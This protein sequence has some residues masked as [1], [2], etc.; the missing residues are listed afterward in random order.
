GKIEVPIYRTLYLNQLLN[1]IKGTKITKN[2]EYKELVSN[3]N[4]ESLEEEMNISENLESTLRYYQKTGFKWLKI[5][6]RYKFGG[7]LADDMGLGKTIQM[8]SIIVDYVSNYNKN[9]EKRKKKKE[10]RAS[11]V[12]SPSSLTLNWQNEA[13]KFTSELETLVIKG[14]AQERRKQL[15]QVGK[16]DLVITSYEL[17]KRDIEIYKEQG[18]KFRF[19]IA[20]EAQ[21]LKNSTT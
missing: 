8:L 6:D 21:Y 13:R 3:L 15:E 10:K 16:Y 4:K 17:L 1:E 20:D 14:D 7:I 9:A 12:I 19:V 11:L 5:L 2:V 18:Y